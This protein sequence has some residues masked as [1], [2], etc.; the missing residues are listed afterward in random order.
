M[1]L[2]ILIGILVFLIVVN[3]ATIGSFVYMRVTQDRSEGVWRVPGMTRESPRAGRRAPRAEFRHEHRKELRK[4]F[5][6]FHSETQDLRI[7]IH[8]LQGEAFALMQQEPVA[9]AQVDSLLEEISI[10]H[11]EISKAATRKMIE[12]REFM[13]PEQMKMFFNAIR[14]PAPGGHVGRMYDGGGR[15]GHTNKSGHRRS[16]G[17][18][19]SI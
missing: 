9:Q 18:R 15:N 16:T 14:G 19:D 10:L 5:S 12:S 1:K 3:L 11:L 13:T 2:R 7:R 17:T 6:E 4:L 8:E